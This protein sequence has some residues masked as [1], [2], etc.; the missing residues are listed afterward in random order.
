MTGDKVKGQDKLGELISH[1]KV[2]DIY[3][4]LVLLFAFYFP[5]SKYVEYVEK[6]PN[7]IARY[8]YFTLRF[9]DLRAKQI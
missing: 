1:P 3:T 5:L 8:F 4:V 7:H 9:L 2:V 6:L